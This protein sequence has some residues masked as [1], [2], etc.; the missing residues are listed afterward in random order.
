MKQDFTAKE[1]K[2]GGGFGFVFLAMKMSEY[3]QIVSNCFCRVIML[4]PLHFMQTCA[5]ALSAFCSSITID[6]E[7]KV[8]E[9]QIFRIY[10]E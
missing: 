3:F 4:S 9:S 5:I 2:S 6:G 7:N 10:T 8:K 1:V